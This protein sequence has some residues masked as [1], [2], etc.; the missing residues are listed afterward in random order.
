MSF[1]CGNIFKGDELGP[2]GTAPEEIPAV[3]GTGTATSAA[4]GI[5]CQKQKS[6]KKWQIVK[7]KHVQQKILSSQ[8]IQAVK[9]YRIQVI[10]STLWV[11][12]SC[13]KST[14]NCVSVPIAT[15]HVH[16]LLN[17]LLKITTSN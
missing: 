11:I 17:S 16:N 12:I 1:T 3:W 8:K 10:Y 5:P 2:T 9:T 14:T 15:T 4:S 6:T 7:S 13:S